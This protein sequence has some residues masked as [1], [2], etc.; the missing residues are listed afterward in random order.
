MWFG[1]RSVLNSG[2][3]RQGTGASDAALVGLMHVEFT[4]PREGYYTHRVARR[5]HPRNT[6]NFYRLKMG[7]YTYPQEVFPLGGRRGETVQVSLGTQRITADLA[8]RRRTSGDLHQ[9]P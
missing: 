6:A 4:F 2:R 1:N 7:S 8:T 5:V 3:V 9:L